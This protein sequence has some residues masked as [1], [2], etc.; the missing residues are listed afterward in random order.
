MAKV[1]GGKHVSGRPC[2]NDARC[3]CQ[4]CHSR[5]SSVP[6]RCTQRRGSSRWRLQGAG[7]QAGCGRRGGA[8]R[9]RR[10]IASRRSRHALRGKG[11]G[12]GFPH[13]Q[14]RD[15]VIQMVARPAKVPHHQMGGHSPTKMRRRHQR[16]QPS[17]LCGGSFFILLNNRRSASAARPAARPSR[18]PRSQRT[19][20]VCSRGM[21]QDKPCRPPCPGLRRPAGRQ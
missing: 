19:V 6:A 13:S 11:A 7:R 12:R 5:H 4:P 14:K 3:P 16:N 15:S 10:R 9:S 18:L 20:G 17:R 2:H 21:Q 8:G 1:G